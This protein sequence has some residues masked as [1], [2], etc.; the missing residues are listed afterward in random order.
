MSKVINEL[1]DQNECLLELV[2]EVQASVGNKSMQMHEL[3]QRTADKTY[4]VGLALSSFELEM[5]KLVEQNIPSFVECADLVVKVKD[6][7][8]VLEEENVQLKQQNESFFHDIQSQSIELMYFKQLTYDVMFEKQ[9][10]SAHHP[11]H[12]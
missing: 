11:H 3:L 1:L 8:E 5:K 2:A 7:V 9:L 12:W 4:N 6:Y 10:S